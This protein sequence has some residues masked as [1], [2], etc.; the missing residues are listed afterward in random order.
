GRL[1]W[2]AQLLTFPVA[3]GILVCLAVWGRSVSAAA[4]PPVPQ[5]SDLMAAAPPASGR[6]S[7]LSAMT[8]VRAAGSNTFGDVIRNSARA[9]SWHPDGDPEADR[10]ALLAGQAFRVAALLKNG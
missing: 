2:H 3:G 6:T 5:G 7:D 4:A 8:A 1:G 9:R 10:Q